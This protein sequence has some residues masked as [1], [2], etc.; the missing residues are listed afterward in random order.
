ML[1][2]KKVGY[3]TIYYIACDVTFINTYIHNEHKL[4]CVKQ[5]IHTYTHI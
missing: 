5:F 3:E 4:K 1:L 2:K